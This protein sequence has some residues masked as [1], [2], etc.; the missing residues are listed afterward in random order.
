LAD[1][2][3]RDRDKL[4]FHFNASLTAASLAKLE[5]QHQAGGLLREPFSIHSL[6]RRAFNTHLL[7]RIIH[8]LEDGQTLNKSTPFYQTLCNYG[9]ITQKAA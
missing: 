7:D 2:Q 6:Q 4:H 9:T 8:H 5:A 1:C 3:A